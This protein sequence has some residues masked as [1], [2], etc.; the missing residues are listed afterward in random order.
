MHLALLGL[1]AVLAISATAGWLMV[2]NKQQDKPV[3]VMMF[4]GYFWLL[5]FLQFLLLAA[6][7]FLMHRIGGVGV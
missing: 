7:Y 1:L 6:G 4:V 2:G 3:R 5:T